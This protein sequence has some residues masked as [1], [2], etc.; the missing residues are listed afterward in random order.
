MAILPTPEGWEFEMPF[1]ERGAGDVTGQLAG[2]ALPD[3]S[4]GSPQASTSGG[5][6]PGQSS[7]GPASETPSYRTTGETGHVHGLLEF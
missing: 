3:H 2:E 7:Q 1:A 6:C 5:A 4:S